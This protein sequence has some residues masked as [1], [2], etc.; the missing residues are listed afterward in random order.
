MIQDYTPLPGGLGDVY[1]IE[2]DLSPDIF[3]AHG[4]GINSKFTCINNSQKEIYP[5]SGNIFTSYFLDNVGY[6]M[7]SVLIDKKT[8]MGYGFFSAGSGSMFQTHFGRTGNITKDFSEFNITNEKGVNYKFAEE[9]LSESILIPSNLNE[10][11][12]HFPIFEQENSHINMVMNNYYKRIH[13]WN[14]KAITNK[15]INKTVNFEY[16]TYG[17]NYAVVNT[18][19]TGYS[20]V[21]LPPN[22]LT[23]DI[24]ALDFL[25]E[26][27][28]PLFHKTGAEK[29]WV[30]NPRKK[31][32]TKIIFDQ[33]QVDFIY[34]NNR[35]D[36]PGE[37]SL[38]EIIVKNF[39]NEI[40]SRYTFSYSYFDSKEGCTL[41]ECKRLKLVSLSQIGANGK[42][43]SHTFDYE[44]TRKLPKRGSLEQDYF[45]YYN[46]NGLVGVTSSTESVY[47]PKLYFYKDGGINSIL[48]FKKKL[49]PNFIEIPGLID[50]TPNDYS[51]TGLLKKIKYPTGGSLELNYENNTFKFANQ[52]YVSGGARI[53]SQI[54]S[55]N[56]MI[57]KKNEYQYIE[58]D[59]STSGYVNNLPVF[60]Y[61]SLYKLNP[62][63]VY[64][65]I[66]YDKPKSNITLTNGSC[67]GYSKV[68][69]KEVDNGYTIYNFTSPK[70]ITDVEEVRTPVNSNVFPFLGAWAE[71]Y[72]C[73]QSLILNSA[74]PS[75][76]RVDNDY[77]RGKLL[78]KE[79]FDKF[80]HRLYT[81]EFNYFNRDLSELNLFKYFGITKESD[82]QD[83]S[84]VF[85]VDSKIKTSQYLNN[86]IIKTSILNS[87]LSTT[88]T[89]EYTPFYPLIQKETYTANGSDIITNKYYC[90]NS[91]VSANP[92][93]TELLNQNRISELIKENTYRGSNIL[94][95]SQFNYNNFNGIIDTKSIS[96]SK[97]LNLLEEQ[98]VIDQRDEYGNIIQYHNKAGLFTSI[99]WGY[100]KSE[101]IAKIE[102]AS[103]SQ[104]I[105]YVSNLQ[106]LSNTGTESNLIVAL[107]DLR[108]AFPNAVIFTYT[109]KP[110]IGI[111]SKT[112]SKGYTNYYEYDEFNRL[113][114][115]K[116]AEGKILSNYQYNYKQ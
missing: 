97:G 108:T 32:L 103:Y 77:M 27:V 65:F 107:N 74:Y 52:E 95:T 93:M 67:V 1:G 79:I 33:G 98:D 18:Y 49:D 88:T 86:S 53:V 9:E 41:P 73:T 35:L 10:I 56:G 58:D 11:N 5:N 113:K 83:I 17:N 78:S 50:L 24:C 80:N 36:F 106:N 102:N 44:D 2:K 110:L 94:S 105:S 45:G 30:K 29:Y 38:D 46:N 37:K 76:A 28:D 19:S 59:G 39:K 109:Y 60:G 64:S 34:N 84:Y 104:I 4:P 99:I 57:K 72:D 89:F 15:T 87:N 22:P 55:D 43:L 68:I 42:I 6:K 114:S 26:P 69:E 101:P 7:E 81:E 96:T 85:R 25:S 63:K 21:N 16:E 111:T 70:T 92:Q 61:P 54:L 115:T 47:L 75:I 51:L 40:V 14:L 31:R 48:P 91:E 112:D 12:D 71:N 3:I 90:F 8:I 20:K 62:Y 23:S 66:V 13:T 116:D 82:L 100:N